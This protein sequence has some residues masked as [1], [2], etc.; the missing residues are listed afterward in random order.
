[1]EAIAAVH[2]LQVEP[3]G[4]VMD[5]ATYRRCVSRFPKS[6]KATDNISTLR[7]LLVLLTGYI[8]RARSAVYLSPPMASLEITSR[9]WMKFLHELTS[10]NMEKWGREMFDNLKMV[11][12]NAEIFIQ[13]LQ[14]LER[15]IEPGVAEMEDVARRALIHDELGSRGV[16]RKALLIKRRVETARD[17]VYE[18]ALYRSYGLDA[19]VEAEKAGVMFYQGCNY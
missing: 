10:G 5:E 16:Y 19:L 15:C 17:I 14:T 12:E 13:N 8:R 2:A 6:L 4:A 7:E 3:L 11:G 9:H 18:L 1:M